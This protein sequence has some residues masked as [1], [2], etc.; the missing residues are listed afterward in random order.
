MSTIGTRED[1]LR[2]IQRHVKAKDL[3]IATT[4]YTGR[5]LFALD[6]RPNQLYTVGSMGCASSL[7][8]GISSISKDK[9]VITLD[10]DGAAL[11]RMGA[12][13]TIGYYRPSNFLHILLNNGLHESTGGQSTVANS[14]NFL[15]IAESC[16][17]ERV[18]SC[19][20][21]AEL[22]QVV[23]DQTKELTFCLLNI[24]P[25]VM[26]DLPRPDVSPQEVAQ[27]FK[28]YIKEN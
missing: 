1:V 26:D 15:G 5:E 28:N 20:S 13:A 23:L 7:S 10:G 12:L 4:G 18:I 19:S 3:L 8:L 6:D 24:E 16:G 22:E 14:V 2:S 17:Y 27:R 11:M 9:R 21:I 25:G